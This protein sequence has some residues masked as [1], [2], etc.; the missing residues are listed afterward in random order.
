M[1]AF[2]Q[3][4]QSKM[5][6]VWLGLG[7]SLGVMV[8]VASVVIWGSRAGWL[9]G[10]TPTPVPEVSVQ[11]IPSPSGL[12]FPSPTI[13]NRVYR[14]QSSQL[15]KKIFDT[16]AYPTEL[17]SLTD[18]ALVPIDCS[19]VFER[20][21]GGNYTALAPESNQRLPLAESRL[22]QVLAAIREKV[23]SS[24]ISAFQSCRTESGKEIVV[25]TVKAMDDETGS[26]TLMRIG[27]YQNNQYQ[28]AG[29]ITN[30]DKLTNFSCPNLLLLTKTNIA[31]FEC[32]GGETNITQAQV[33]KFDMSAGI[34][35][36]MTTC[37][38]QIATQPGSAH[39]V[40]C[41]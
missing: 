35:S 24:E 18:D 36:V 3:T 6:M 16:Q 31:Y 14:A 39:Q 23:N 28:P 4:P 2:T 30:I 32:R 38:R 40:T 15:T 21:V 33:I 25:V 17:T 41:K 7:L 10:R 29:T 22:H 37:T 34:A 19:M 12:L 8:L 13:D 9:G 27:T 20:N 5:P 26:A 11:V 1:D